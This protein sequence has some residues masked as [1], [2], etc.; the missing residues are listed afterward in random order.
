MGPISVTVPIDAP[1]ERVFAVISDLANRPSFLGETVE[2]FRLARLDS[3][4]VGAAARFRFADGGPW[5]AT[6]IDEVE[7]PHRLFERGRT[8][9]LDRIPAFTAWELVE[10]A[11]PGGCELTVSYW[12]QPT[13]PADRVADRLRGGERRL[14]RGWRAALRRLK[15]LVESEQPLERLTVGGGDRIPGAG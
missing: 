6:A 15:E 7:P 11:G 10:G 5:V 14:R 1:R 2:D 8:G 4:G 3:A 9:R 13:H 12:T